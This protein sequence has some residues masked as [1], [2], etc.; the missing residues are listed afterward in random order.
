MDTEGG[1]ERGLEVVGIIGA[2]RVGRVLA[3][4]ARS[5]GHEVLI[6]GSSDPGRIAAT[7]AAVAPGA[8]PVD[9]LTVA[10]D[11]DVVILALP[12]PQHRTLPAEA[13][14]G[15][16]V[17]D[18]MNYWWE[19]DGL[20]TGFAD[21][22]TTTSETVQRALPGARVVK[23][24]NHIGY[25]DLADEARPPGAANRKAIAVAGDD[26]HAVA[27]VMRLVDDLGF[28]PVIAGDLAAGIMLE[29]GAE[30]FGA[31]VDAQELQAMLDR[32]PTSQRGIQVARARADA[33]ADGSANGDAAPR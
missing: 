19:A 6:A 15:K 12:L 26:H 20:H 25:Q 29:P 30:A 27:A 5:A 31:D 28:D 11:A 14:R 17:I 9:A 4:L 18:A 22:R 8:V 32:F 23:A 2:G 13:L 21:L 10:R 1:E 7:I 16:V 24:F 33:R 3:R